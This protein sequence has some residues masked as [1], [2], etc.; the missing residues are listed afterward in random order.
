MRLDPGL[1]SGAT[2]IEP[3]V[4]GSLGR[5]EAFAFTLLA[6]HGRPEAFT[7]L[8]CRSN[9]PKEPACGR[10]VARSGNHAT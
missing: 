8:R 3:P 1:A 7:G 4:G 5:P 2:Q 6:V 10:Q 9:R